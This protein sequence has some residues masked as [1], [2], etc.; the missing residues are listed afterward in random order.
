VTALQITDTVAGTGATTKV[1]SA[2]TVNYTVWL[3][4]ASAP[5]FE[6]TKFDSSISP[7]PFTLGVGQVIPGWDQGLVGMKVGGS[8]TLIIPSSLA[9]GASGYLAIPPNA[10]LVFTVTLVSMP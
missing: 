8:R 5:N 6:G 9:Y 2:V 4:D 3:Y 7:L 10:A 1:G